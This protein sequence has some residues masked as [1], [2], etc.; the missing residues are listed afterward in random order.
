IRVMQTTATPP[1][2]DRRDPAA[3]IAG[4]VE[5]LGAVTD[6]LSTAVAAASP[7]EVGMP[8]AGA[9]LAVSDRL[10]CAVV[11]LLG[12]VTR[13][14]V[15]ATEGLSIESW[16]RTL[17]GR[18]VADEKMLVNTVER[19][20]DLP[21]VHAWFRAGTITW[22]VVRG[23]VD[24]VRNLTRAQRRWVDETLAANPDRLVGLDADDVVAV[25]HALADA[26]RPDLRAARDR[27]ERQRRE[28]LRMQPDFD[29][30]TTGQFQFSPETSDVIRR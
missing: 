22:P 29:G 6:A 28:Y 10:V 26:A 12:L 8:A 3:V 30:W 2:T 15:I 27:R 11:D 24:A 9:V 5:R 23:I 14:G 1:Q 13:R 18:T 20:R 21:T 17:A 16:L 19:L 7:G 25:V 4:L